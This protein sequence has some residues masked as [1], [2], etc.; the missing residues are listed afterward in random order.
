MY[1]I[2]ERLGITAQNQVNYDKAQN[3]KGI[4]NLL[5]KFKPLI[6]IIAKGYGSIYPDTG[7]HKVDRVKDNADGKRYK[8]RDRPSPDKDARLRK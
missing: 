6:G 2:K 8:G 7:L 5:L 1:D 4:G 3:S